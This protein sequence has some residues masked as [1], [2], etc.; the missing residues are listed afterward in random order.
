MPNRENIE[1]TFELASSQWGLFTT[2]Q[3][4][5]AGASRTQLSRLAAR[6]RIEPA[7]YGTWRLADGGETPHSA[8]KAAWLSLYPKQTAYERLR[9]R[10]RDAVVAGR[11]AACMHGDTELHESPY[12]FA[13]ADGKR[14]ARKDVELHPWH[15][16]E[17]DVVLIDGL[18]ATSVERTVADLVRSGEDPSLVGNFISGICRRGHVVDETRLSTLLSPLASRSGFGKGDGQS[19]ARK[20]VADHADTAQVQLAANSLKRALEASPSHREAVELMA[21]A[22]QAAASSMPPMEL[23]DF[24]QLPAVKAVAQIQEALVPYQLLSGSIQATTQEALRNM[25]PVIAAASNVDVS[26]IA[27]VLRHAA[28]PIRLAEATRTTEDGGMTDEIQDA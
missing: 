23:P 3:A 26:R 2:A 22:L 14:S 4:L 27:E 5:A 25:A 11:T 28:A 19:F 20:L 12:A 15:V 8:V 18:P 9:V 17:A 16:D 6:G 1:S 13:V 21:S 10:P 7:S 24:S